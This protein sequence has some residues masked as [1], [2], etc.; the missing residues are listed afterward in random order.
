VKG[1]SAVADERCRTDNLDGVIKR[2]PGLGIIATLA[3]VLE[4][5]HAELLRVTVKAERQKLLLPTDALATRIVLDQRR[6]IGIE[7]LKGSE[8][9]AAHSGRR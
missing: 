7:Y 1:L 8:R 3:T 9:V 5:E 2:Y 4:V 6:S